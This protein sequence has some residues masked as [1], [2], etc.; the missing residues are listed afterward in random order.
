LLVGESLQ[1][2]KN[3]ENNMT[4]PKKLQ[5]AVNEAGRRIGESHPRAV[6][7]DNEVECLLQ[8]REEGAGYRRLAKIFE[9]SKRHVRDICSGRR[10]C[11]TPARWK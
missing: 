9:I 1:L 11:Q 2:A 8:L 3:N 7:T 4:E 10:R 5:V 6:L